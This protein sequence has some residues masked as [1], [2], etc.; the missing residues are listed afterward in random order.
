MNQYKVILLGKS[1]V[2]KSSITNRYIYDT[3]NKNITATIGACYF[4]KMIQTKFGPAKLNLWD[5][6]DCNKYNSLLPM[7]YRGTNIALI[8]YDVTSISSYNQCQKTINELKR[9][10]DDALIILVANK[11]DLER[12]VIYQ[13]GLLL[14]QSNNILYHECSAKTGQGIEELFNI[15]GAK[16][17]IK[18]GQTIRDQTIRLEDIKEKNCCY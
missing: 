10:V 5:T 4:T 16:I 2:G 1:Y 14:A 9:N 3:F 13:D 11:I 18:D 6:G 15:I 17:N 12:E 7:Y 8:V